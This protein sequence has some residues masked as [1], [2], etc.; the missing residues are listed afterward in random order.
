MRKFVVLCLLG[1]C[2]SLTAQTLGEAHYTDRA[3]GRRRVVRASTD[4]DAEDAA[5]FRDLVAR[6]SGARSDADR[7]RKRFQQLEAAAPPPP[8]L[9]GMRDRRVRVE[10]EPSFEL[11]ELLESGSW[12][13]LPP[14]AV[15]A[16][17]GGVFTAV[18]IAASFF[19][20]NF[21]TYDE[22]VDVSASKRVALG[23]LLASLCTLVVSLRMQIRWAYIS[24]RLLG[25]KL[26]FE[27]TGWYDGFTLVKPEDALFRDR[28][29][30]QS[31]VRPRLETLRFASTVIAGVSAAWFVA[32]V[33]TWLL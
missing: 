2:H 30:E 13:A 31:D 26:Y 32:F 23:A 14:A 29:L 1:T 18:L 5:A 9:V 28:L 11:R 25:T 21:D 17:Y 8:P 20:D 10:Q 15:A 16:R 22:L 19:I 27:Q 6:T 33:F 24:D 12:G 3:G 4:D 7:A